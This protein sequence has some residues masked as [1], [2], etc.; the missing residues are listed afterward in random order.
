MTSSMW[1]SHPPIIPESSSPANSLSVT[2]V[3]FAFGGLRSLERA[4]AS[5]KGRFCAANFRGTPT[6]VLIIAA[7]PLV[8]GFSSSLAAAATDFPFRTMRCAVFST[9]LALGDA[10]ATSSNKSSATRIGLAFAASSM[11]SL[12]S[13]SSSS[14][15]LSTK[16]TRATGSFAATSSF[17]SP[18]VVA[19]ASSTSSNAS[20]SRRRPTSSTTAR[21]TSPP[22]P[23]LVVVVVVV[24]FPEPNR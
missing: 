2:L 10:A 9:R 23:A 7:A 17:V 14:S 21:V 15:S 22:T 12:S 13:S 11:L 19:S 16:G 1:S 3:F 24:V 6:S 4:A 20:S 8:L 5:A 18:A